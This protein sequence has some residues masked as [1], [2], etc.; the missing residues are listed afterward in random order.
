MIWS[1]RHIRVDHKITIF[2]GSFMYNMPMDDSWKM[3]GYGQYSEP[4]SSSYWR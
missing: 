1:A 4:L 2:F 3:Y